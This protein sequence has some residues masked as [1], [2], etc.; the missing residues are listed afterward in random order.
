MWGVEARATSENVLSKFL[1]SLTAAH[2]ETNKVDEFLNSKLTH[3][4]NDNR[5]INTQ[6]PGNIIAPAVSIEQHLI[7]ILIFNYSFYH[8]KPIII[9]N[10]Y[11]FI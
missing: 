6:L 4:Y 8:S 5:T 1:S 9:S 10:P 11:N 3:E 2:I 7:S